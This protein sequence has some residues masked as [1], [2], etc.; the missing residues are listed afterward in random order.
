MKDV[1]SDMRMAMEKKIESLRFRQVMQQPAI[2]AMHESQPLARQFECAKR[3]M[4]GSASAVIAA[5][6]RARSLSQLPKTKCVCLEN[7]ATVSASSMSP[8]W[9]I[10]ST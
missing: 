7:R 8:Q 6:M 2:V 1:T 4:Q 9:I 5:R 3:F 10:N